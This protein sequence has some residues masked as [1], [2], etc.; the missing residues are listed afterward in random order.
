MMNGGQPVDPNLIQ[1]LGSISAVP[2]Q[3]QNLQTQM[4]LANQMRQAAAQRP[5]EQTRGG[6]RIGGVVIPQSPLSALARGAQS[7]MGGMQQHDVMQKMQ[8][9]AKQLRDVRGQ[10]MSA[11]AAQQNPQNIHPSVLEQSA[12]VSGDVEGVE[13]GGDY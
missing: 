11:I 3:N 1:A 10:Y 12:P 6:G 5:M 7:V 8:E 9:Q 2:E 13:G 4:A